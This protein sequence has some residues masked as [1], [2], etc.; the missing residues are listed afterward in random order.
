MPYETREATTP[1]LEMTRQGQ[2]SFVEAVRS[3]SEVVSRFTSD[4]SQP[5][6]VPET[7]RSEELV[8][9]SFDFA[10]SLLVQQRRF[11]H[12]LISALRPIA[13][14][15]RETVAAAQPVAQEAS[16]TAEAPRRLPDYESMTVEE[17]QDRASRA[18][19]EGRSSMNKKELVTALRKQ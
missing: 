15:Q 6:A 9:L 18:G 16:Q 3:W 12:D 4:L 5:A 10:Q 1:V 2:R 17:L 19:I 11:A 7:P 8:D 13:E 14:R